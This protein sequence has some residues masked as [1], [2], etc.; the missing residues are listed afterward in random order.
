[1]HPHCRWSPLGLLEYSEDDAA[2]SAVDEVTGLCT[3]CRCMARRWATWPSAPLSPPRIAMALPQSPTPR[4]TPTPTSQRLPSTPRRMPPRSVTL[5]AAADCCGL[6]HLCQAMHFS[7]GTLHTAFRRTCS[8]CAACMLSHG[9]QL[10]GN[11]RCAH[12]HELPSASGED[13]PLLAIML[14]RKADQKQA[15]LQ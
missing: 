9:S 6:T 12:R 2:Q 5:A 13:S 8:T 15:L 10:V 4:T 3:L 7:T 14:C 1:M 11:D